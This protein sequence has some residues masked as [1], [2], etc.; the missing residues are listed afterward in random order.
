MRA[1]FD[2]LFDAGCEVW[3]HP[4]GS[5]KPEGRPRIYYGRKGS[6]DIVGLT[7]HGRFIAVEVKIWPDKQ[8]KEQ[9]EFQSKVEKKNG[10][11]VLV[12]DIND[13]E[14]RRAEIA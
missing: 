14:D 1:C 2:W 9:K 8:T 5:W 10:I 6:G 7:R 4:T 3:S 11:Y 13:L 12:Y